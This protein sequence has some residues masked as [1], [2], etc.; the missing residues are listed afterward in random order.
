MSLRHPGRKQPARQPS[1]ATGN[2]ALDLFHRNWQAL[3]KL[4]AKIDK[5]ALN[6]R[7]IYQRFTSEIEPLE[8]QQCELIFA[9]AKRLVDFTARK[10]FTLWQRETLGRCE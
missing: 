6:G 5:Q 3:E 2:P 10:S 1:P 9:L 4:Q 8:R 7:D